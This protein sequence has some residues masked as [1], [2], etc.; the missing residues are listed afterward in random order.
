[1]KNNVLSVFFGSNNKAKAEAT[2]IAASHS[3]AEIT[4]A[5]G[6]WSTAG[7][8]PTGEY[9]ILSRKTGLV[10]DL[11]PKQLDEATLRAFIGNS[12]CKDH[13]SE[14]DPKSKKVVF[15]AEL[16]AEEIRT[17]CDD[18]GPAEPAAVR[19]PGLYRDGGNRL[20][21]NYG[22]AVYDQDGN[23]V[24]TKPERG[25][26]YVSGPG[27]GF[28]P[29]TP[30]ANSAEV[31]ELEAVYESFNFE[32]A[33]GASVSMGWM[34]SSF[35]GSVLPNSPSIFLSAE[36]GSGKTT[37]VELQKGLLG[38]Q[39]FRRDGVPTVAQ[40]IYALQNTSAALLLDE[41]Q[42]QK[43]S[44]KQVADLAEV[45]NAGFTN[46][47]VG[48]ITR[49]IGGQMRHFNPPAGVAL[50]GIDLPGFEDALESRGV[51]LRMAVLSRSGQF[52]SP[53]LDSVN[54]EAVEAMGARIRRLLVTRWPVMNGTRLVVHQL[55]QEIGHTSRAADKLSPL[56]AGYIALKH[57]AVPAREVLVELIARWELNEV[58]ANERESSKE[59][60]LNVLL[61]RKVVLFLDK[62]GKP[63]KAH[64][65]VRDAIRLLASLKGDREAR[66]PL[67]KQL[68]L[69]GLKPIFQPDSDSWRLAVAS[70]EHNLG[71]RRMF[72]ATPW[73]AGGWADVLARLPGATK[74][75]Q[76]L[77]GDSVKV[78]VVHLP[79]S[80]VQPVFDEQDDSAADITPGSDAMSTA[81]GEW[82]D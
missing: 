58:K 16:L 1:M 40:V 53:L 25:Q 7:Y 54:R 51:R 41:F 65:R 48:R 71:L 63:V 28:G 47:Q 24:S 69:L 82:L 6:G 30:C 64:E 77:A 66:R 37:W 67:E 20:T 18:F 32:Q 45:F 68:E 39:A 15:K 46:A 10:V 76:R 75:N 38:P 78:V 21:V 73:A 14:E 72:Q 17:A 59:A 19:G 56:L 79:V 3:I 55:L 23:P 2:G 44:K 70:S 26:V 29:D 13:Y 43:A 50:C 5:E 81:R 80:V 27:L 35:F 31:A 62:G 74:T 34:A 9:R 57:E 52:K 8:L 49:V 61:D 33:Y 36:L 12:Y 11:R 42:P 4:W 22:N 60:C